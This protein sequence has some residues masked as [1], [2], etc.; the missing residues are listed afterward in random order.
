MM[1]G[2]AGWLVGRMGSDEC[3]KTR[4]K[5]NRHGYGYGYRKGYEIRKERK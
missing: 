5:R 2:W 3:M 1:A 4:K